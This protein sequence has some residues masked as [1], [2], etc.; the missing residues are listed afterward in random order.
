MHLQTIILPKRPIHLSDFAVFDDTIYW[1][2]LLSSTIWKC[3]V[4][5][6]THPTVLKNISTSKSASAEN[7]YQSSTLLEMSH[8]FVDHRSLPLNEVSYGKIVI[9]KSFILS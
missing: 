3:S 6:C 5:D 7:N 1:P 9:F 4:H 2:D 8:F